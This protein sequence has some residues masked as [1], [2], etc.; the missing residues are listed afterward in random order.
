MVR[1]GPGSVS[2]G[3]HWMISSEHLGAASQRRRAEREVGM[4]SRGFPLFGVERLP[5]P[6]YDFW[7]PMNRGLPDYEL[8]FVTVI[9]VLMMFFFP[10]MAG[11]YSAVHGP[12][13]ALRAARAAAQLVTAF[14]LLVSLS[15]FRSA[16][17][18][19]RLAQCFASLRTPRDLFAMSGILRC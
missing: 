8:T 13:T 3:S 5:G 18:R 19:Y 16:S 14:A 2:D 1:R 15:G 9:C 6:L 7:S 10:A 11:P 17:A 4:C 12:A